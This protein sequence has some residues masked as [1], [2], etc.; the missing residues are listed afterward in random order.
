MTFTIGLFIGSFTTGLLLQL[1]YAAAMR[2]ERD[3]SRWKDGVIERRTAELR[4]MYEVAD[5]LRERAERAE[6][7]AGWVTNWKRN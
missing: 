1:W 3:H 5:R 6:R 4:G 7:Q 2:D